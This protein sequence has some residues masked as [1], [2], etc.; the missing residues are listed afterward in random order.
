MSAEH[1][2]SRGSWYLL[3]GLLI[4]LALGLLVA[5]VLLGRYIR[6]PAMRVLILAFAFLNP[7]LGYLIMLMGMAESVFR[8]RER[9]AA[10]R[11]A[12]EAES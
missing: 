2:P 9:F 8:L 10:P 1:E 6:V 3:T 11:A 7:L 5:W 4:G 12:A